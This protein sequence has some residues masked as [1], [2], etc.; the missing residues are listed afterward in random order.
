MKSTRRHGT[1]TVVGN[2]EITVTIQIMF[3]GFCVFRG[4]VYIS[5]ILI[6]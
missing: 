2:Y 3:K 1:V 4:S 5:C 6:I